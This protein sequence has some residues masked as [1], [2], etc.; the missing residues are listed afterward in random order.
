MPDNFVF[1]ASRERGGGGAK[2]GEEEDGERMKRGETVREEL[3]G[4]M[5]SVEGIKG[6]GGGERRGETERER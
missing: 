1:S 4:I 5:E 2:G 6:R 3:K